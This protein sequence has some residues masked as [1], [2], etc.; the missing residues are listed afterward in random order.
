MTDPLTLTKLI[1]LYM[2]DKAGNPMLKTQVFGFI[3]EKDY[4]NY[5]TLMQACTEL[6]EAKFIET[7]IIM[8][9]AHLAILE[10]GENTLKSFS[11]RI[12]NAIKDDIVEFF[13]V[14]KLETKSSLNINTNYYKVS[15]SEYV[16]ELSLKEEDSELLM[17]KISMP[18]EESVRAMCENFEGQSEE[19]YNLI[20][21]KL[22]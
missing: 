2:L 18:T 15:R 20:V 11:D 21:D 1:I 6:C 22:L 13:R 14:N 7:R 12:S 5:F 4:T 19:L 17:L 10:D 16:A 9:G 3:M 8:N